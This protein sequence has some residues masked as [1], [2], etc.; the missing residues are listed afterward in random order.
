MFI[1]YTLHTFSKFSLLSNQY[2]KA[3]WVRGRTAQVVTLDRKALLDFTPPISL[4]L[5]TCTPT[6]LTATL[7]SARPPPLHF[8]LLH[9]PAK[10]T[11]QKPTELGPSLPSGL[12]AESKYI[13]SLL[14]PIPHLQFSIPLQPVAPSTTD[15][16]SLIMSPLTVPGSSFQYMFVE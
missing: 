6:P 7:A 15:P 1:P 9:P 10:I 8:G 11:S 5:V 12:Y 3:S 4:W 2:L 14:A 13:L 16:C